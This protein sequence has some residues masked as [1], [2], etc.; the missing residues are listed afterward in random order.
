MEPPSAHSA[1]TLDVPPKE[2]D[3]GPPTAQ[4]GSAVHEQ[5][6]LATPGVV[7]PSL[8]DDSPT[9]DPNP[10]LSGDRKAVEKLDRMLRGEQAAGE[11][12]TVPGYEILGELGRGGMGVVYK[13]RQI[14]LNRL[15]A[16]KMI[17][18][19]DHASVGECERF[20]TEAE[21][22]ARLQHPNIVQI[23]DVGLHRDRPY[24]SLEYCPGGSL[25]K[26]LARTPQPPAEAARLL[27]TLA[28]AMQAAHERQIVHRDLKPA[29]VL[30][31]DH[32][33]PK[34]T[35]FGLAKKLD[36]VGHTQT[37]AVM[38]TPSY[39]APE[40]ARGQVRAIGPA[41]DV[42]ALGAILY[43]CL[44]GKPP[45][46]APTM[47]ETLEQV[48]HEEP[49][50]PSR[51]QPKVPRDLETICLKCLRKDPARRYSSA[52]ALAD[53]LHRFLAGET[54]LARPAGPTERAVRWARRRPAVATLAAAV[55]LAVLAIVVAIPL[56]V[57]TL[58]RK[59]RQATGEVQAGHEREQHL[60]A[61]ATCEQ[62]LREAQQ[63]RERGEL[64]QART[65][66]LQARDAIA[67][68]G[69][70]AEEFA[71][72]RGEAEDRLREVNDLLA[73]RAGLAAEQKK[74]DELMRLRDDAFFL[75][76]QDVVTGL[77][78]ASPQASAAAARQAL[79][80]Y[81]LTGTAP[82]P[83][84]VR[85]LD[86]P[87][88]AGLLTALHEVF[89]V[90]A[91]ATVRPQ[92]GQAVAPR[93][94]KEALA[95]LDRADRVSPPTAAALRRKAHYLEALGDRPAAQRARRRAEALPPATALDWF[96]AGYDRWQV[97]RDFRAALPAFDRALES[98]PGL[99][100]A[101][102]FRAS[103]YRSLN[104]RTA[105][106]ND[107]TDCIR[108]RP[109]FA[110]SYVLRGFLG[111]QEGD[112]AA[113]E[114]DLEAALARAGHDS[115]VRYA[116]HANRG[117]LFLMRGQVDR[118]LVQ[119]EEAV[120]LRPELHHARVSL[121]EAHLQRK[122]SRRALEQLNSAIRR[123]PRL[124]ELYRHRARLH[125][126]RNDPVAAL[127]DLDQAVL[128]AHGTA[129]QVL[130]ADHVERG[131]LLY[132]AG[133]YDQTLVACAAAGRALAGFAPA[134]RLQAEALLQLRRYKEAG[135]V[136][137]R[138]LRADGA[139]R[140]ANLFHKAALARLEAGDLAGAIHSC[141]LGLVRW[142][143]ADLH[144]VRGW[145]YLM[146]EAPRLAQEDFAA[147][148]KLDP[149]CGEA[150]N[151]RGLARAALGQYREAI[152]DAEQALLLG[153]RTNR[154][155]YS[156]ARIFARAAE[157]ATE[158]GTARRAAQGSRYQERAVLLLRDA[159]RALPADQRPEF[160]SK[161]VQA[162]QVFAALRRHPGFFRLQADN[163]QAP[164]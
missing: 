63:A 20:R 141:T 75:L 6:T 50:P 96:L 88:R 53:D 35:D 122:D 81:G 61:R 155:L 36:E 147:A 85:F 23:Y 115:M 154:T 117:A 59:V 32:G 3:R 47:V 164:R 156:A 120:R 11:G 121:A 21:A 9:V 51:L 39:M 83:P 52:Q 149:K 62:R 139:R 161:H 129:P 27:A 134:L 131:R 95:V 158:G 58:Q 69:E 17:L 12:P 123:Q 91:E 48:Q 102:F 157:A 66:L 90:L 135:D 1:P 127:A 60:K 128:L 44:T 86:R 114:R 25:E 119:L 145:A 137:D 146:K 41:T 26:K 72:L 112:L 34:V 71:S 87:A 160:W 4:G 152:H 125:L 153:P 38:G 77:N 70:D 8:P 144:A 2:E 100:W 43:E 132:D 78:A 106:R 76:N 107:L 101:R 55:L 109:A 37:G 103:A 33:A 143:S 136:F 124:A 13:A 97:D 65:L 28:A 140:D 31:D 22:V 19:A 79:A 73:R 105:A 126:T 80:L 99:F 138:Y 49:I 104:N 40:Q 74:R 30:L 113:A 67:P 151:G 56:H 84:V 57:L 150:Y 118:A 159:L 148:L 93:Q 68:D 94:W 162:E 24:F 10:L 64:E 82:A 45:F 116:V 108:L 29:N 42:Y 110:W 130:A 16:L 92:P 133:K 14:G 142:H 15:V 163:G 7:T 98:D 89:L 46:K 54:I 5:A 111:G 18:H